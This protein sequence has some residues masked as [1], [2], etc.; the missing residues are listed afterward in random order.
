[1]ATFILEILMPELHEH[2]S[3]YEGNRTYIRQY[4]RRS[5]NRLSSKVS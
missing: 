2:V 5:S 4:Y 1:M 3:D